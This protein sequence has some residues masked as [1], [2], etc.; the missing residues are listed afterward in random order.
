M[1]DEHLLKEATALSNAKTFSKA[2]EIA[3]SDYVRR[4]KAHRI[5]DLAGSGLWKGDLSLMRDDKNNA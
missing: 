3:L 2:V 1:L 5:L 4:A